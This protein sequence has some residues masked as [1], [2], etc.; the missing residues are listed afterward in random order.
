MSEN[1][2]ENS[3]NPDKAAR[4]RLQDA[5]VWPLVCDE[6]IKL[7]DFSPTLFAASAP[8]LAE[9]ESQIRGLCSTSALIEQIHYLGTT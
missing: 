8:Q 9:V 2:D 4:I 5:A 3:P 6:A 7:C 1:F